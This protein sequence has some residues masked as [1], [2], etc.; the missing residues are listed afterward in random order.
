MFQGHKRVVFEN[1]VSISEESKTF[2]IKQLLNLI[3]S[4]GENLCFLRWVPFLQSQLNT[5]CIAVLL[6]LQNTVQFSKVCKGFY[7]WV[8]FERL[9]LQY[10]I[11]I[12]NESVISVQ[13]HKYL[14]SHREEKEKQQKKILSQNYIV[15]RC[16][17]KG[18]FS[19]TS[20]SMKTNKA[21]RS[22]LREELGSQVSM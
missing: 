5:E 4:I 16:Y 18:K 8:R 14:V 1:Q 3:A 22:H 10:F 7:L 13:M 11:G 20:G 19:R 17:V 9:S 2:P 12:L 15:S 6:I 21:A